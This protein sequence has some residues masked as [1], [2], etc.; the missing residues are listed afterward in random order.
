[1][2]D[3]AELV[4][5]QLERDQAVVARALDGHLTAAYQPIVDIARNVVVGYEALL[6]YR[7]DRDIVAPAFSASALLASARRVGRIAE[8]ES[9]ALR[10][11]LQVRDDLAH[12]CFLSLN[13]SIAAL[14]DERVT[15]L[16]RSQGALNG[17]VLELSHDDAHRCCTQR[18]WRSCCCWN[19][20]S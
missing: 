9:A 15:Q 3:A 1:M 7:T 14:A 13:V 18:R 19:R 17:V 16:L 10:E 8:V 6:R 12:D 2:S 4:R 20:G 5:R 11:A